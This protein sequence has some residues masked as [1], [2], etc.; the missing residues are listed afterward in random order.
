VQRLVIAAVCLIPLCGCGGGSSHRPSTPTGPQVRSAEHDA[1]DAGQYTEPNGTPI[2]PEPQDTEPNK[3]TPGVQDAT[4][5]KVD[6]PIRARR[7]TPAV[8]HVEVGQIVVFTDQDAVRH[9][10]RAIDAAL[11]HSGL[12]PPGG[13]F[14]FTPLRPGV[15]RFRCIIH[16]GMRG[17]LV[18]RPRPKKPSCTKLERSARHELGDTSGE[19]ETHCRRG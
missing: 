2:A 11:P 19:I 8:M 17:V 12:I 4:G 3:G 15:V 10:V 13:R 5:G 14:E 7:F 18:V 6:V 1:R 9:T 16:P